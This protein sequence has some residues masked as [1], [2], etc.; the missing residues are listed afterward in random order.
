[1][2]TQKTLP[3]IDILRHRVGTD[4][5]G[6]PDTHHRSRMSFALSILY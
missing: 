5:Q 4:G 2:N 3:V 1:M 6:I